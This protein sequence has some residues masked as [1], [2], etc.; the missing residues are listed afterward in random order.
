MKIKPPFNN[1]CIITINIYFVYQRIIYRYCKTHAPTHPPTSPNKSPPSFSLFSSHYLFPNFPAKHFPSQLS[2]P[3]FH[4][5]QIFSMGFDNV[6]LVLGLGFSSTVEIT[7]PIK[8]KTE[9]HKPKSNPPINFEPPSLTL[10]LSGEGYGDDVA[11]RF[12]SD[13]NNLY[14]QDSGG[15]SYSNV[16][17]KREREEEVETE[18]VI[19]S[20]VII[21]DEDDEGINGRKKLRL[22]KA[23]SA[24]LEESFKQHTTLNPVSNFS[25]SHN[26]HSPSACYYTIYLSH[27]KQFLVNM[28]TFHWFNIFWYGFTF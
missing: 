8:P 20:R 28:T 4:N 24:L 14:G 10:A 13:G 2:P 11:K 26:I 1:L 17:V 7:T 12:R 25:L 5:T 3:I 16:S 21:S 15:S 6:G 19:S 22:T 18:R 23:Q 9:D 27:V